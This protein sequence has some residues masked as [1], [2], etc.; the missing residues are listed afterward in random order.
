MK[1]T[2]D[3]TTTAKSSAQLSFDYQPKKPPKLTPKQARTID[4]LL[5]GPAS[6]EQVDRYAGC[7]NGPDTIAR[8][9]DRGLSLPCEEVPAVD[10][11]GHR[12]VYGRYSMTMA[13]RIMVQSWGWML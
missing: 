4:L 5:R 7:S 13:D 9:R 8:L 11:D 10:R 3:F 12:C 1:K 6:R 2:P